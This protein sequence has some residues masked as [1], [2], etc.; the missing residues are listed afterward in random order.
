MS[1]N[2]GDTLVMIEMGTGY[3]GFRVH[4]HNFEVTNI[5]EKGYV[6]SPNGGASKRNVP[7]GELNVA[8]TFRAESRIELMTGKSFATVDKVEEVQ[9][10]MLV[11]MKDRATGIYNNVEEQY[12][13]LVESIEG[14]GN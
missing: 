6:V 14:A 2:I 11:N 3:T 7:K 10:Q 8:T 4:H 5:T 1:V 12:K 9:A 13:K